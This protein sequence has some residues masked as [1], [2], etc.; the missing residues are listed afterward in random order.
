MAPTYQAD[1]YPLYA[2][3]QQDTPVFYSPQYNIWVITRYVDVSSALKQSALFSS[4]SSIQANVNL[5]PSVAAV[6]ETNNLSALKFMVETDAPVHTSI[7]RV[8]NKAFTPQRIAQLEPQIRAITDELIDAFVADGQADFMRQFAVP[9]LGRVICNLYGVP[10]EDFGQ[11]KRWSDD[12][13]EFLSASG[14]EE[15]LLEC[16]HSLVASQHYFMDQILA[17]Q[18]HPREDLLTVMLPVEMGGTSPLSVAE[19]AYN[20]LGFLMAGHE[21]TTNMLGNSLAQLLAHPDQL[22]QLRKNP[23]LIPNAVEEALRMDTSVL[24]LFRMTTCEVELGGVTIPANARV[25][26]LYGAANHD[27]AQFE[28]P[29]HMDMTRTNVREHLAFGRGI[30]ACVGAPLA[31]LE[32]RIALERLLQRLPNLRLSGESSAQRTEHFWMR[33]FAVLPIAWDV[34]AAAA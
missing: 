1:P 28:H 2:D 15:R 21:P 9:L 19:A 17:R 7:R 30:H 24:G 32:L 12:W 23:A 20:A 27:E 5:P 25:L 4:G 18:Q 34:S 11:I 13:M 31:R 10:D 26:L 3:L 16:A 29:A 14:P 8:I 33:G 22:D 6:I